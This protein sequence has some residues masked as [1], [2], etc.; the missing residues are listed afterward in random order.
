MDYNSTYEQEIDLKDLMFAVLHKWR[1]IILIAVLLAIVL[2]GFKGA[3]T[4]KKQNDPEVIKEA[5]E[6]YQDDLELFNKNKATCEREIENLKTDIANQQ[7]YLEKSIWIN[8]SPYDVCESRVD[9]Y[10]TTDYEIMPGMVYQNMD[11]TDTILQAYQALLTSSAVMEDV[12]KTVGTE[13][14]YLRELVSVSVGTNSGKLNHL[15]TISVK[16]TTKRDAQKVMDEII[17]HMNEMHEQVVASIGEHTVNTVNNGVSASVDL[18]LADKQRSETERLTTLNDS[19]ETKQKNLEDME[20]P[21]KTVSSRT[22]ALKSGIKYA[23]LGGVLGGFMVVFFVCVAFLMSDK[24]YS[25]RELKNRYKL[26]ILGTMPVKNRRVFGKID[27]WLNR[28]EGRA[29]NV[30]E[31]AEYALIAANIR[32][33][34]ESMKSILVTGSVDTAVLETVAG[35]LAADLAG[36]KVLVGGNM[37]QDVETIKKLPECDGVVLVEQCMN[38]KYS[39]VELEIERTTDLQKNVVGCVVFE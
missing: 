6:K 19:L 13:P 4:Y 24:V 36:V 5:E 1:P 16:H 38:T 34:A 22:A 31:D 2:G 8:M 28:L 26:K 7:E 17:E 10:I 32:N 30:D 21:E 37:L 14:R 29:G 39:T 27:A 18:S 35:R 11:Y 9:L 33:Y 20:E 12:A 25:V 15:L 3:T 23:V